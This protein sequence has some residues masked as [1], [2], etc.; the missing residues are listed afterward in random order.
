MYENFADY[1]TV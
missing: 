1:E